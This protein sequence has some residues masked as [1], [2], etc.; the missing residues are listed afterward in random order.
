M[1]GNFV[2]SLLDDFFIASG[3]V[4]RFQDKS[5]W[6]GRDH[7]GQIVAPGT[8]LMHI[9]AT[10]WQTGEYSYD[11]APVVVGVYK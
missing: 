5:D 8:Y 1:N 4:E 11:M 10:N 2:T 9:E 6:D 3:T 7:H